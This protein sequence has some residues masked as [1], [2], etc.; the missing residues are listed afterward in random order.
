MPTCN[1][2]DI[3]PDALTGAIIAMEGISDGATILNGP[4]GCKYFHGAISDSQY[5]RSFS[6]DPLDYGKVHYFGQP[7]VP[8]TYLDSNDYVFGSSEK[9]RVLTDELVGKYAIVSIVNSPG[10]SLLAEDLERLIDKDRMFLIE[11][12]GFSGSMF[13]GFQNAVIT[14]LERFS[15]K[16]LEE[17]DMTVNLVG[18]SIY[19]KHW[20]GNIEEIRSILSKMGIRVNAVVCAGSSFEDLKGV[21][22]AK[23]NIIVHE[24]YGLRIA[25]WLRSELSMPFINP[26]MGAPVGFGSIESFIKNVSSFFDVDP[27]KALDSVKDSRSH[28]YGVLSRYNSLSG[29]PRGATFSIHS[30]PSL[31]LPLLHMLYDYLG[32]I[33]ESISLTTDSK[34]SVSKGIDSYLTSKGLGDALRELSG[35]FPDILLSDGNTISKHRLDNQLVEGIE[36]SLPSHGY[37]DVLPKATL[38]IK[39]T[40]IILEKILNGLY[41][42]Y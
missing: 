37:S 13:D 33:P 27:N 21:G 2:I 8:T 42:V 32:M 9:V 23:C 38:G 29:L 41:R 28:C 11:T 14:L 26:P 30:D 36:I 12:T 25:E 22:K 31:A 6:V 40:Y 17:Q 19:H 3:A 15:I 20:Q 7:R 35:S 16:G 1:S 5:P 4:T 24:E 18:I 10:A 34:L 39:G